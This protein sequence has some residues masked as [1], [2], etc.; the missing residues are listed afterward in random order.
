MVD[1]AD[2]K[3]YKA[4]L[5]GGWRMISEK[6][7]IYAG[8][9]FYQKSGEKSYL[10]IRSE[11]KLELPY[12]INM[13]RYNKIPGLLPVQFF[14]EDGEYQYFYD[15]SDKESLAERMKQKKYSMKEIRTIMSDL[16]C[17]VQQLEE[18]L[19]DTNCLILEPEYMF[20]RKNMLDIQFCFYQDKKESF[21][22]SL[23]SLFEYFMNRLDYQDE[24]TVVLVYGLYQKS[25]EEHI[26]LSELMKQ[27]C[28]T[29]PPSLEPERSRKKK[30]TVEE[31]KNNGESFGETEHEA[32]SQEKICLSREMK[33]NF[34]QKSEGKKASPKRKGFGKEMVFDT[35]HE[36][37]RIVPYVPDIIGSY[38]IAR[39]L[40]HIGK[41][42]GQMSGKQFMFWMFAVAGILAVC[43][44]MS[45]I[46]SGYL[47]KHVQKGYD[48]DLSESEAM[49]KHSKDNCETRKE[50]IKEN[51]KEQQKLMDTQWGK[52]DSE[53]RE[54]EDWKE[55][56]LFEELGFWD[57]TER[58]ET[59]TQKT[60][61]GQTEKGRMEGERI[62]NKRINSI[63][64]TV[65][66]SRP[67]LF[68]AFN[69]ILVSKNKEKYPD[70]LLKD[71]DILIGKVRGITDVCLE[72]KGISRIH[73]RI[74]QDKKGCSVMDLGST[75][76][77]FVNGVQ[78]QE[79][80]RQ[81]LEKGD[82]VRFAE[83]AYE[84]LPVRMEN[85][86]LEIEKNVI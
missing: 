7:S 79:R 15:I 46:L 28:E 4:K 20:S 63:P 41:N 65:V 1:A 74:S 84:F 52:A 11:E 48:K 62:E 37:W 72:G 30:E 39:I 3:V 76:G 67:E 21:E 40:W 5:A 58:E 31:L 27:F 18:Y 53:W 34:S 24:K 70:I 14:I 51:I 78:L 9:T 29:Q 44:I 23:E 77:T 33:R 86:C 47:K 82:E 13:I 10:V 25:K 56:D 60:E 81:Y 2:H 80:Q 66:M 36:G 83:A 61:K 64:A 69:P 19:L 43:G 32:E 85:T 35:I 50:S 54:T 16:Y 8:K 45:T 75:N 26:S 38:G 6:S 57:E 59:E 42:H 68:H 73:A 71:R 12:Q 49:N 22:K 55:K 17:C